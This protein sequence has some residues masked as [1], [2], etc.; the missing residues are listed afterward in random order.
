VNTPKEQTPTFVAW[1]KLLDSFRDN[2]GNLPEYVRT[3]LSAKI[4]DM[5]TLALQ[6]KQPFI[7][8]RLWAIALSLQSS[9]TAD[10]GATAKRRGQMQ[11]DFSRVWRAQ[12]SPTQPAKPARLTRAASRRRVKLS[13][14]AS[15]RNVIEVAN[16]ASR[17]IESD[18]AAVQKLLTIPLDS[19]DPS[20]PVPVLAV[21]LKA[22]I[23]GNASDVADF[24]FAIPKRRSQTTFHFD[25][26]RFNAEDGRLSSVDTKKA[27][28]D[29]LVR[30]ALQFSYVT[31]SRL[32]NFT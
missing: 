28:T 7:A 20:V 14:S 22:I 8:A 12:D 32:S 21:A 30:A 1:S 3:Q 23:L 9:S 29:H 31:R 26:L 17:V 2:E 6:S 15:S 16:E 11:Y 5:L 19:F 13:P 25:S 10:I 24:V 4:F 27:V 18:R